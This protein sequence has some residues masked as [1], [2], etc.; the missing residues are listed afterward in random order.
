MSAEAPGKQRR[1]SGGER[2]PLPELR[3]WAGPAAAAAMV[4]EIV[5][6]AGAAHAVLRCAERGLRRM[7][8][9]RMHVVSAQNRHV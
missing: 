8:I 6:W 7:P 4:D 9:A 1:R 5:A 3:A 2:A